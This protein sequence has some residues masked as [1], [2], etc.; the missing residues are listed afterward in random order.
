MR[1]PNQTSWIGLSRDGGRNHP[2]G[3]NVHRTTDTGSLGHDR[4]R[5]LKHHTPLLP[6]DWRDLE[7]DDFNGGITLWGAVPAIYDTTRRPMQRGIHVHARNHVHGPKVI[8]Q[9]FKGVRL[10]R[11]G[12]PIDG[13]GISEREAVHFMISSV[14]CVR[15]VNVKCPNCGA[16]HLDEGT[17]SVTPTILRRCIRCHECFHSDSAVIANP[18]SNLQEQFGGRCEPPVESSHELVLQQSDFLGGI[19]IWGSNPA[20]F[21]TLSRPEQHGIHVHAFGKEDAEPRTD[22]TY[23]R[24]VIDGEILEADVVRLLMLQR[25]FPATRG[26]IVSSSCPKCGMRHVSRGVSSYTPEVMH[27]CDTCGT[28]FVPF[29]LGHG[30]VSNPVVNALKRI[31][32][33]CVR[34]PQ[35]HEFEFP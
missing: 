24:V 23:S 29:C 9:T 25:V 32:V 31:T 15:P 35:E 22:D 33:H 5:I 8:D 26:R 7:I 3:V 4:G 34:T 6:T 28:D 14:F 19:Q 11:N 1:R 13:V 10:R 16:S 27:T 30:V 2:S 21:S 18:V 17:A 20:F 12:L